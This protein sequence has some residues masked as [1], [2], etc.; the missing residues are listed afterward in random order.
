MTYAKPPGSDGSQDI[1]PQSM[2]QRK[3]T[4]VAASSQYFSLLSSI[5]VRLRRQISA[6]ED[7]KIVP[8]EAVA[9]EPQ[10][11]LDVPATAMPMQNNNSPRATVVS[12]R[13]IITN[14]GLGNLDIG[15]L[16]SRNSSVEKKMEAE[17]WTEAHDLVKKTL[18]A[19]GRNS[20][21]D[22][23]SLGDDAAPSS[24]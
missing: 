19:K 16:N 15:W 1:Q 23:L 6:L 8:S 17:L 12:S 7:A 10:T 18:E 11:S 14:G 24:G 5:D 20:D 3:E 21:A 2:E 9:K 13:E 4:F 22:D